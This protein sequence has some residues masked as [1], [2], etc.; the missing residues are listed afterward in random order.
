MAAVNIT[1]NRNNVDTVFKTS[2]MFE[3]AVSQLVTK[4]GYTEA[5]VLDLAHHC[6]KKA[7]SLNNK[8]VVPVLYI[9]GGLLVAKGYSLSRHFY[10][11]LDAAGVDSNG[12]EARMLH[13]KA[14][15]TYGA[16]HSAAHPRIAKLVI[17]YMK[18]KDPKELVR[19]ASALRANADKLSNLETNVAS[20]TAFVASRK[21]FGYTPFEMDAPLT[22]EVLTREPANELTWYKYDLDQLL[23]FVGGTDPGAIRARIEKDAQDLEKSPAWMAAPDHVKDHVVEFCARHHDQMKE[24]RATA[25]SVMMDPAAVN[26][27]TDIN[28]MDEVDQLMSSFSG[29]TTNQ[30]QNTNHKRLMDF[31]SYVALHGEDDEGQNITYNCWLYQDRYDAMTMTFLSCASPDVFDYFYGK[32]K[33]LEFCLDT[34]MGL[35]F[36]AGPGARLDI[37]HVDP[38][39]DWT[40]ASHRGR[41]A[42]LA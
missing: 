31:A 24:S 16:Q 21:V 23:S 8:R 40:L 25:L 17:A 2:R 22:E 39:L 28:N 37:A 4:H 27:I 5:R 1:V 3:R 18:S 36:A 41:E 11:Y 15:K 10:R 20:L 38:V 34:E 12:K 29:E 14:I 35:L 32:E 33:T 13:G 42:V 19:V 6:V 26:N 30:G 7:A 9:S